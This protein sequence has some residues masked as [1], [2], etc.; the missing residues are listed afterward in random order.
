MLGD[1]FIDRAPISKKTALAKERLQPFGMRPLPSTIKYEDFIWGIM[2]IHCGEFYE[3][4]KRFQHKPTCGNPQKDS[5]RDW[6]A[7][8][9]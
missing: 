6:A 4:R 1:I 8:V 3:V 9:N 2:C 7:L 5:V